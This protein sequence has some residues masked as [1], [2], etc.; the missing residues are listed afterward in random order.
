[1]ERKD[2]LQEVYEVVTDR[3]K[4]PV[5]G[6]YTNYLFDRGLDKIL[7]KVGEECTEVIIGGKNE[8]KDEVIYEVSDLL[9]HLM[10]LMVEKGVIWQEI[11]D[12]LEKRHGQKE[13]DRKYKS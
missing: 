3:K 2:V 6:S 13:L 8:G 12:E 11:Y 1:M 9:H 5:E 10:V 4:N 7:K